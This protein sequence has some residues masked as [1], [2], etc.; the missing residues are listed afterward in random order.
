[1][2]TSRGL[3]GRAARLLTTLLIV[4][5]LTAD[6]F[7]G[8]T[9]GTGGTA[10]VSA[11]P[12]VAFHPSE[13]GRTRFGDLEFL[14]GLVL[15]SRNPD[16]QSLSALYSRDSGRELV[17]VSDEGM[18]IGFRLKT[19]DSGRPL[20]VEDVHIAPLLDGEGRPFRSK[21]ERDAESLAFRRTPTGAE[22]LVGYEG[23][24]RVVSH[25]I[26]GDDPTGAFTTPGRPVAGIPRDIVSLRGNRGLE[27]LAVAPPDTPLAGS[28]LLIAEE[29]RPGEADQPAWI[30]GGPRPGLFHI[31][32][33]DHFA[34]T[35]AGFLPN[36]DL[37]VLQRRFGLRIGLGMRL[38]R[39]PASAIRPGR[40]VVPEI[41]LEADWGWEIDNM[42]GLAVDTAP[43]GSTILTLVSDDNGAW[44][45]RTVL[46]RF[47][48]IRQGG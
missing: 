17:S 42:E 41:L 35:D 34:N 18:W 1:M 48:L 25:A 16:F 6:A 11:R 44:F 20:A 26:T 14:G 29:P 46:L 43:D 39:I 36:G 21:W 31:A 38:V 2:S 15:T 23:R 5:P 13:P 30:I 33:R 22:F 24:H 10:I 12:I 45:Q 32:R 27:G 8:S 7:A 19:D 37:V 40:T 28:L 9:P 47:R 4:A 3:A